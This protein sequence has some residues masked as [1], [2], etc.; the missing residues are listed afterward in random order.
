[1]LEVFSIFWY[2]NRVLIRPINH[3]TI[4][5]AGWLAWRKYGRIIIS[6]I[7]ST[8]ITF[9]R[10]GQGKFLCQGTKTVVMN[11]NNNLVQY[12]LKRWISQGKSTLEEPLQITFTLTRGSLLIFIKSGWKIAGMAGDWTFNLGSW[13]PVRC[14]WPLSHGYPI[15]FLFTPIIKILFLRIN[16]RKPFNWV[17]ICGVT[18]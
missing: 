11:C 14:L 5:L 10:K 12:G 8:T 6:Q 9:F 16:F 15:K 13:F 7:R 3:P 1:M 17:S 2:F 18:V 4:R